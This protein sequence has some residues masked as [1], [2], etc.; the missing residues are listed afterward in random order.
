MQRVERPGVGEDDEAYSLSGTDSKKR[1]KSFKKM[2][3]S[4]NSSKLSGNVVLNTRSTPPCETCGI[5]CSIDGRGICNSVDKL[6][7]FSASHFLNIKPVVDKTV[8]PWRV[9]SNWLKCLKEYCL[10]K[11]K[12]NPSDFSKHLASIE[13][14][15]KSM[16]ERYYSAT[17]VHSKKAMNAVKTGKV[18]EFRATRTVAN[19]P[20]E[21]LNALAAQ[22]S[23]LA[24]SVTTLVEDNDEFKTTFFASSKASDEDAGAD[25]ESSDE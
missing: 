6:G 25:S 15:L 11:L 12:I 20:E 18:K 24:K 23:L 16:E 2:A 19:K 14:V 9:K 8:R 3:Q 4:H 10:P 1:I 17:P 5:Y 7:K 21:Q 13:T 22:V